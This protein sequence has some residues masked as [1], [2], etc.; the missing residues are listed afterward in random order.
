MTF[1][2]MDSSQTYRLAML[3]IMVL[4]IMIAAP[5][6]AHAAE[7]LL[8]MNFAGVWCAEMADPAETIY[9]RQGP[10]D[11]K[12]A[13]DQISVRRTAID[14]ASE[15][16][17][18]LIDLTPIA[19]AKSETFRAIFGCISLTDRSDHWVFDSWMW[20]RDDGKLGMSDT[21]GSAKKDAFQ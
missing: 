17:C 2:T 10:N 12:S 7:R 6:G 3:A 14:F 18:V 11:C 21:P 20:M 1:K 19:D 9:Q 15:S 4:I 16:R 13:Q 5:W 8:P